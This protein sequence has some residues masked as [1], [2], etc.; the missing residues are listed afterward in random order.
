MVDE[1]DL[2][3]VRRVLDNIFD[4]E[5]NIA[6]IYLIVDSLSRVLMSSVSRED[7]IKV[8]KALLTTTI[9]DYFKVQ[10]REDVDPSKASELVEDLLETISEW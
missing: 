4:M 10:G 9:M 3:K 7:Q 2:N 5:P 8:L 6:E 1:L